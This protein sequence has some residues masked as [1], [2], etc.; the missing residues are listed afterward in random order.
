MSLTSLRDS[1]CQPAPPLEPS[2]NRLSGEERAAGRVASAVFFCGVPLSYAS[3]VAAKL[4]TLGFT[5]LTCPSLGLL[6]EVPGEPTALVGLS[7]GNAAR[8]TVQLHR[9]RPEA[10]IVAVV[11]DVTPRAVRFAINCGARTVVG[12]EESAG[13]VTEAI[14]EAKLGYTRLSSAA[15]ALAFDSRSGLDLSD[16]EVRWMTLMA[17]PTLTMEDIA[18][19]VGWSPRAFHRLVRRLYAHLGVSHRSEAAAKAREWGMV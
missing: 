12:L 10:V 2:G 17:D 14:C 6:H 1:P 9:T 4:R 16:N 8:D 11:P 3:A 18:R 15:M 5:P 19:I 13:A 7:G